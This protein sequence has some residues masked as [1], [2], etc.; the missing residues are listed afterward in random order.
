MA[1]PVKLK[2]P[3]LLKPTDL[4]PV[5]AQRMTPPSRMSRRVPGAGVDAPCQIGQHFFDSGSFTLWTLAKEYQQEH[6]CG[7]FDFYQTQEFFD[8]LETYANFITKHKE[9]FDYYAN[10]DVIPNPELTWRSQRILEDK[11]DLRPVPVVHYPTDTK[12]L[13]FYLDKKYDFI[14]LGG[15]VGS[16]DTPGCRRWLN[17][18]FDIVCDNPQ[19]LPRVKI[20]G[21]GV[22]TYELL[23]RYPFYSIDSTTWAQVGAYGGIIVPHKRRGKFVFDESPYIIKVSD[24]S[25]TKG[26]WGQHLNTVTPLERSIIMEWLDEIQVPLGPVDVFYPDSDSVVSTGCAV[27]WNERLYANLLFFERLRAEVPEYPWPFPKPR[28]GGGFNL[29]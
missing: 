4:N 7:E 14:A 28:Q 25:P 12:W 9:A 24:D 1:K 10:V 6:K 23:F 27:R 19:R 11:Y 13:K 21:F 18:C 3:G 17:A 15:L 20:H 22:L 2:R 5:P 29:C 16:T 8:Y 26:K